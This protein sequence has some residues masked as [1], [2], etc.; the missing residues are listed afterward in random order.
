MPSLDSLPSLTPLQRVIYETDLLGLNLRDSMRL[1]TQR[2]GFFVGQ[3]RY[4]EERV[5]IARFIEQY[6]PPEV[7]TDQSVG[8][9][10]GTHQIGSP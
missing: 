5:K 3:H 1:V 7:D 8:S 10:E 9:H 6:G 2:M 4:L